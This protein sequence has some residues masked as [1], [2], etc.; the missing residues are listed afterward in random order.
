MAKGRSDRVSRSLQ[1]LSSATNIELQPY[2]KEVLALLLKL[3]K[4]RH[5]NTHSSK[6]VAQQSNSTSPYCTTAEQLVGPESSSDVDTLVSDIRSRIEE[7]QGYIRELDPTKTEIPPG[8]A[9]IDVRFAHARATGRN[10]TTQ[11]LRALAQLSLAHQFKEWNVKNPG[12]SSV[13]QQGGS[14]RPLGR[15][16][17]VR[18]FLS[19]NAWLGR[20]D[21]WS[22]RPAIYRGQRLLTLEQR[23]GESGYLAILAFCDKSIHEGKPEDVARAIECDENLRTV[24]RRLHGW[25]VDWLNKYNGRSSVVGLKETDIGLEWCTEHNTS[26]PSGPKTS[27]DLCTG[28]GYTSG[29]RPLDTAPSNQQKRLRRLTARHRTNKQATPT[30]SEESE[31]QQ[32]IQERNTSSNNINPSK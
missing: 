5:G 3:E 11:L 4:I 26:L 25:I 16:G 24:A 15:S 9:E 28:N 2:R 17:R 29:K 12:K 21:N 8:S 1:I 18:A 7:I 22:V 32:R 23:L 27:C 10:P 30:I 6:P 13:E 31:D 20:E 19:V 14:E